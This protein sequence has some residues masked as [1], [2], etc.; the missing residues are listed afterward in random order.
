MQN[1]ELFTIA[2]RMAKSVHIKG[3]AYNI[4]FGHALKLARGWFN[5][6]F[7]RAFGEQIPVSAAIVAG[8]S[9]V[10]CDEFH[11]T[12]SITISGTKYPYEFS[13]Y[14]P[15]TMAKYIRKNLEL[16][17]DHDL[18]LTV[19]GKSGKSVYKIVN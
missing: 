13:C 14:M 8:M 1:S 4:T 15:S 16:A 9:S 7:K 2:H 18:T 11:L 10:Y 19:D 6:I 17:D 5:A 12:G 3:D